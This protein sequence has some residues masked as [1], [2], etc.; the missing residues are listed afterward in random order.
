MT[1]Y[2]GLIRKVVAIGETNLQVDDDDD[3]GDGDDD[4]YVGGAGAAD[5]DDYDDDG[6]DDND[7]ILLLCGT[8]FLSQPCIHASIHPSK[9]SD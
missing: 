6:N 3:D 4:D 7:D 9:K 2:S 8:T 1:F 5:D